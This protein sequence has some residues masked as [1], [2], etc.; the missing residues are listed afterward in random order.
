[1]SAAMRPLFAC[2][3]EVAARMASS[4]TIA[5]FLDFDGTLAAIQPRPELAR[6]PPYV[7]PALAA[8][9]R[10]PR[11]RV[12]VISARR[13]ADVRNRGRVPA[14]RYLGLY[15]WE[16]GFPLPPRSSSIASVKETLAITLPPLPA[17]WIE[18][19]EYTLAVHYRGAPDEVRSIVAEQVHRALE[20]W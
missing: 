5:L 20:P 15:G 13:R 9:A 11:F 1:M 3:G 18:D 2:W 16:R 6:I 10:S 12:W 19:K 17:V 14:V 4:R 7:R 8:L